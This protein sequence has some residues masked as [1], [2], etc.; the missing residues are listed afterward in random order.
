MRH[1]T[2]SKYR[3]LM[4]TTYLDGTSAEDVQAEDVTSNFGGYPEVDS[5]HDPKYQT[6]TTLDHCYL[7]ERQRFVQSAANSITPEASRSNALKC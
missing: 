7:S 4:N 2:T 1:E 5:I 6:R 3:S